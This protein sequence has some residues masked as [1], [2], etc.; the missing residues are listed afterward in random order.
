MGI[1]QGGSVVPLTPLG[2]ACLRMDLTA[3][4]EIL[5]NLAYKDDEGAATEV[6]FWF[7]FAHFKVNGVAIYGSFVM[8]CSFRSM[9]GL[10]RCRTH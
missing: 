6:C 4:H 1:Q 5:E 2:D 9:C 3:V 8:D 7:D 10:N